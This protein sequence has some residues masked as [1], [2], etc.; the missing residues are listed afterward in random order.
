MKPFERILLAAAA[1][2]GP[3]SASAFTLAPQARSGVTVRAHVAACS[4]FTSRVSSYFPVAPPTS[5]GN[6]FS[7]ARSRAGGHA[8]AS[9]CL[10]GAA[11]TMT[12][13]GSSRS[14]SSSDSSNS[15][16]RNGDTNQSA[17][18]GISAA[19]AGASVAGHRRKVIKLNFLPPLW[20]ILVFM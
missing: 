9:S 4:S 14:R 6:D 15:Y 16:R 8:S 10:G 2:A 12:L 13:A 1:I 19:E 3:G 7:L 18:T 17:S 11:S 5:K 20:R